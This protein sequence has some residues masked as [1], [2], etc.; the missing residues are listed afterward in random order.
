MA[1]YE[2]NADGLVLLERTTFAEA[3]ILERGDLQ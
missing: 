2:L 1:I 3:G